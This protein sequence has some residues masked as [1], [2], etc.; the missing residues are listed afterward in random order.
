MDKLKEWFANPKVQA[1]MKE[2]GRAAL[3]AFVVLV[4]AIVA[5]INGALAPAPQG[6]IG[7]LGLQPV[8][9][10]SP[11]TF[12]QA[13]TF[14]GAVV[15]TAV[16]IN[17]TPVFWGT[18]IPAVATATPI[19]AVATA[20]PM[21]NLPNATAVVAGSITG[22]TGVFTT[23]VSIAGTPVIAFNTPQPT[24]AYT[25]PTVIANINTLAVSTSVSVQGTPVFW[26]TAIP[27]VA[28]ATP[29][30]SGGL[31][32]VCG[33]NTITGTGTIVHGLA[34]P[35]YVTAGLANDPTA[36]GASVTWTNATAVVTLKVWASEPITIT[37]ATTPV[38][39][40]WC[41]I[42]TK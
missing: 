2:F 8:R 1:A 18:A 20:T 7:A 4:V 31:Y 29:Q 23:S 42:G 15:A 16:S 12:N 27:A 19:P 39:V 11:E 22:N 41:A 9:H 10:D 5:V 37:A 6:G 28:T 40:D 13:V 17:G 26:A 33:T 3:S 24:Y 21:N 34:T 30:I 25:A 38:A 36:D 32:Q 14:K 35:S